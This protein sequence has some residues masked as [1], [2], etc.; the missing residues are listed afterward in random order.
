MRSL[1]SIWTEVADWP[2][3]QRLALA[4]Q[5]LQSLQRDE[6]VSQPR[7]DALRGLIGTWKTDQPLEDDEVRKIVDKERMKKYS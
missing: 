6:C 5:L 1:A 2:P 3:E 4:T 7:Q